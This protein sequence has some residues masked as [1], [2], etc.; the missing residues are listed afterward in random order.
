VSVAGPDILARI[1]AAVRERLAAEPPLPDLEARA[2]AAAVE[3]RRAGGRSLRAALATPGVRVIAECKHRSPSK[4]WLRDPF[5]PVALGSA[6]AAGG[7]AAVS[8]V[9][10]PDFFAGAAEWVTAVRRE[11][12]VPVLQKDFLVAPRQV[13]EAAVLGAD[14]VL[15]IARV[16]PGRALS[17]MLA[18]AGELGLE[19]LVEIHDGP[20]LERVLAEPAPLVGINARDLATFEVDAER[21]ARV[22]AGVPADRVAV[23][24]S[25]IGAPA[26][27]V[28]MRGL[29]FR[30]FLVGEY[31]VRSGDPRAALAELV[32]CR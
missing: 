3:R 19:A 18:L 27:V 22:A 8:V 17:E 31:L 20:E 14:A 5:D 10:E 21:A 12:A 7:A 16:L 28:R 1:V 9:T 30:C 15:L 6:Y 25:G 2:R 29:G 23:L 26:D 13:L 24:E 11:V 32:S 4:G